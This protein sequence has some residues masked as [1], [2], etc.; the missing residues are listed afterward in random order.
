MQ[1]EL[2]FFEPVGYVVVVDAPDEDGPLVGVF[3]ADAWGAVVG[4]EGFGDGA[5]DYW[6]LVRRVGE[7]LRR[8]QG[9]KGF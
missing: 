4:V 7:W 8:G 1:L 6:G 2:Y 5:V 3:G 9:E